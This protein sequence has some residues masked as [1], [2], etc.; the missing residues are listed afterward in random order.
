MSIFND[1]VSL[2]K[3][4]W[5]PSDVKAIL[6]MDQ[7]KDN[8]YYDAS[9]LD[10][11]QTVTLKP[12]SKSEEKKEKAEPEID[13]KAKYEEAQKKLDKIY[14]ENSRK[15]VTTDEPNIDYIVSGIASRL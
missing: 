5:K 6:E 3:A 7:K 2:A 10:P 9:K 8:Q 12:V 11:E 13:Y 15:E 14:D 4:G 1:V